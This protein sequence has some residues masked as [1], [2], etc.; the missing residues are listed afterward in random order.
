MVVRIVVRR[1][2]WYDCGY[3]HQ[4]LPPVSVRIFRV[5]DVSAPLKTHIPFTSKSY[6][7]FSFFFGRLYPR[8]GR[9]GTLQHVWPSSSVS[10]A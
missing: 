7:L 1:L 10:P 3:T 5:D 9:F 2:L 8:L 4:S 6:M